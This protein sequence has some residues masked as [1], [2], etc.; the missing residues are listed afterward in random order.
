MEKENENKIEIE[1][2]EKERYLRLSMLDQSKLNEIV[3]L[4]KNIAG[5]NE[6]MIEMSNLTLNNIKIF[7]NRKGKASFRLG[8]TNLNNHDSKFSIKVVDVLPDGD[9]LVKFAFEPNIDKNKIE[10]VK[11]LINEFKS[12]LDKLLD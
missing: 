5:A 2:G 8:S 6:K 4:Y 9:K 1:P 12:G 3:E 7:L 10:K 11:S